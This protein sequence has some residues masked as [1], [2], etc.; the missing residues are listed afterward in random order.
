MLEEVFHLAMLVRLQCLS[1]NEKS[2]QANDVQ[3]MGE[4]TGI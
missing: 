3:R 1:V 2:V 4:N